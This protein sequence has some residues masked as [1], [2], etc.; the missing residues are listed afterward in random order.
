MRWR[1][2][3][4]AGGDPQRPVVVW[5]RCGSNPKAHK[6]AGWHGA[7]PGYNRPDKQKALRAPRKSWCLSTPPSACDGAWHY[8]RGFPIACSVR[9]PRDGR[10]G[11][12]A[13]TRERIENARIE[14]CALR[15][16]SERGRKDVRIL[17]Q[18]VRLEARSH[19]KDGTS[20]LAR[21]RQSRGFCHAFTQRSE[22]EARALAPRFKARVS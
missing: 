12:G 20:T 3:C 6:P 11:H 5:G 14:T 17:A 1:D 21:M 2:K 19:V 7:R 9:R 16:A 15:G 4:G 22:R 10:N 18:R 8:G 13:A